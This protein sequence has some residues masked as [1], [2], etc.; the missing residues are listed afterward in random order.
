MRLE[1]ALA[2]A[3]D[4]YD[5][6]GLEGIRTTSV[7][8]GHDSITVEAES[9]EPRYPVCCLAQSLVSDG[10]RQ[11]RRVINDTLHGGMAVAIMF[12]VRRAKC[13]CCGKKGMDEI[14]PHLHAK[15]HVTNRLY[16]FIAEECM[17][18]T[19]SSVARMVHVSEGTTRAIVGEEIKRRLALR[20]VETPRVLGL[21][22]K[23]M[24]RQFR[25]VIG[26]VE[27]RTLIDILPDRDGS[28]ED[29]LADLPDKHRLEVLCIDMHPGYNRVARRYL[30]GVAVVADKFHVVRR[31][32]VAMDKVRWAIASQQEGRDRA[33][34]KR[35][36]KIF[37]MRSRDLEGSAAEKVR[38]WCQ[39]FPVL[40]EAYWAK[41]R[42]Y[43]MYEQD[44]TPAQAEAYFLNWMKHLP[45]SIAPVFKANCS[46]QPI[47]RPAV[48][49]YFEHQF[50]SGYIE[51]VNRVIDDVQRA[52]RGYSFEA[53]RGK[54]LLSPELQKK[55]F[56][57]KK[58][59]KPRPSTG[60]DIVASRPHSWTLPRMGAFNARLGADLDLIQIHL[61]TGSF[62]EGE[63]PVT[64]T[65]DGRM[66]VR[67]SNHSLE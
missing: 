15:R 43:E 5:F 44:F 21:D 52:G 55:T 64:Y 29:Y 38:G 32:N 6:L 58:P 14:V 24:L 41:E 20:K 63:D 4:A 51:A 47:W 48:F 65:P 66:L 60:P 54:L 22:E 40:G 1:A 50:T 8:H 11:R 37:S 9:I 3:S 17:R 28:L 59:R 25:A 42:Y 34:L 23:T 62:W 49:G 10:Y 2:A 16:R 57:P 33:A 18:K 36:K 7:T 12:R 45:Q 35:S 13:K 26:N 30:P 67:I 46:I 31:A 56:R 19:N 61:E 27:E 53:I 39:R